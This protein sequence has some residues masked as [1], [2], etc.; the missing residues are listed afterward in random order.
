MTYIQDDRRDE[1]GTS[2]VTGWNSVKY[3]SIINYIVKLWILLSDYP[4]R[5]QESI[6]FRIRED[7]VS[8]L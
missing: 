7:D 3:R 2:L 8:T 1:E 6:G 4:V 5:F